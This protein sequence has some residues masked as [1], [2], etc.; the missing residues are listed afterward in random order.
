MKGV[1]AHEGNARADEEEVQAD[2]GGVQTDNEEIQS[3]YGGL[4]VESAIT[5]RGTENTGK[6]QTPFCLI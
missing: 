6:Y 5:S 3:Q 1:Q 2:D 4:N